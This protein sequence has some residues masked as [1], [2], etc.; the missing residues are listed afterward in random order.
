MQHLNNLERQK[1]QRKIMSCMMPQIF[2]YRVECPRF[3]INKSIAALKQHLYVLIPLPG[4]VQAQ[5]AAPAPRLLR[6]LLATGG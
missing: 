6:M 3:L 2:C 1:N 4:W 5:R